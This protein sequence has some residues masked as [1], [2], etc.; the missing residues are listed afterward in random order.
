MPSRYISINTI[1]D[2]VP[3][4][5][6]ETLGY[7]TV[8]YP[9]IPLSVNDIYVITTEGDRL[10]LLAQQFYNDINLYWIISAANPDI[11]N[12]GSFFLNP[13]TELRIPTDI[14]TIKVLFNNLNNI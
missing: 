3:V 11:I 8:K 1:L 14:S 6:K 4:S 9:E 2:Q 10:D 12:L 5:K 7:Q 13:G